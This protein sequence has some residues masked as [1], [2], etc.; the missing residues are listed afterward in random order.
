MAT[1]PYAYHPSPLYPQ[2]ISAR[3]GLPLCFFSLSLCDLSSTESS[4]TLYRMGG[5]HAKFN[6]ASGKFVPTLLTTVVQARWIEIGMSWLCRLGMVAALACRFGVAGAWILPP[7]FAAVFAH[8][9]RFK[10]MSIALSVARLQAVCAQAGSRIELRTGAGAGAA[11]HAQASS[12]TGSADGI[13]WQGGNTL[14]VSRD[15]H[16]NNRGCCSIPV[17]MEYMC[18]IKWSFS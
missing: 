10:I 18:C 4:A 8:A 6:S 9:P 3:Q 1:H 11:C 15:L 2:P 5:D 13:Y 7:P 17:Q 12:S 16:A 14:Q